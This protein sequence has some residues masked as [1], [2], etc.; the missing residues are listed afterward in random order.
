MDEVIFVEVLDRSGR[1]KERIRLERLP[2]TIGRSYQ[3]DVILDDRFVSPEHARLVRDESGEIVVEDLGSTNGVYTAQ[4]PEKV[5]RAVCGPQTLLR[6]G[7]S[8]LRIRRPEDAVEPAAV[9]GARVLRLESRWSSLA[10]FAIG[11]ILAAL[12][13]MAE[14]YERIEAKNVVLG[15]SV[16]F[17]LIL[18]WAAGWALA[19]RVIVHQARLREHATVATLAMIASSITSTLVDLVTFSLGIEGSGQVLGYVAA[20]AIDRKSVV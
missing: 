18:A 10:I 12:F 1:L 20:A 17:L 3:N 5:G 16:I 9:E 11:A 15:L 14:T 7:H 2:A 4:P 6:I 19:S 13:E 8:L